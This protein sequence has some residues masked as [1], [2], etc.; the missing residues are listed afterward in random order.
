MRLGALILSGG[1]SVRMGEDKGA[2]DWLGVRAVDRVARLARAM[3]AEAV[4]TVGATDYGLPHVV[5]D[6]P[7]SGP[8]G[9]VLAGAAALGDCDRVLVLAVDAPTIAPDDLVLLLA[10]PD[11]GAAFEGLHLPMV[12]RPAAIPADAQAGW[13]MARLAERASLARLPCP[14]TARARLRGA[15]TPAERDALLEALAAREGAQFRGAG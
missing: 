3:G 9:G 15:N 8:V 10:Q 5:E 14:E 1:G 2:A 11:P 7:G 6:P 12:L 13:P 4:I